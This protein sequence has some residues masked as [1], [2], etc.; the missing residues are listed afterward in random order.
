MA[1]IWDASDDTERKRLARPFG[2]VHRVRAHIHQ[3][4]AEK[5]LAC[6]S[7][8]CPRCRAPIE[9]DWKREGDIVWEWGILQKTTGCNKMHCAKCQAYFC[10]LCMQT[11]AGYGHFTIAGTPCNG[12]LFHGIDD[13]DRGDEEERDEQ[14]EQQVIA[15]VEEQ[16]GLVAIAMENAEEGEEGHR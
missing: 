14:F 16:L 2:G 9:V 1:A 13:G 6:N 3:A 11:I 8:P 10:W 15:L 12:Q 7:R 5:W 4:M